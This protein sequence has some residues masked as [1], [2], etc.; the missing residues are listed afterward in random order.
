MNPLTYVLIAL[1]SAALAVD[2][3]GRS[4]TAEALYGIADAIE[5]G[6]ATDAHMALVA[7]KLKARAIEASDWDDVLARIEID[8]AR[9]HASDPP[10]E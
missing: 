7:E 9:L 1:R 2:I 6:K 3:A 4:N 8:S 5:A 10:A